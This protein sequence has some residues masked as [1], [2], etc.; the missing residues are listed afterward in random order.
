M[1]KIRFNRGFTFVE[2]VVAAVLA[3]V[4]FIALVS[5][6]VNGTERLKAINSEYLMYEETTWVLDRMERYIINAKS[7]ETSLNNSKL[8]LRIPFYINNILI[9]DGKVEFFINS[10]DGS[11]RINDRRPGVNKF[12]KQILPMTGKGRSGFSRRRPPYY[13]SRA[14][15]ETNYKE[16]TD[17]LKVSITVRD[18]LGNMLTLSNYA[19]MQNAGYSR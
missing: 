1:L 17:L 9:P 19:Q 11:L 4:L 13:I 5:I 6:Y 10:R 2:V 16:K 15:Y 3:S 8:T 14:Y 18:T 7:A 12:N